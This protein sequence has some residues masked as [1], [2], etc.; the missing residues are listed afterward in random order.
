MKIRMLTVLL[1]IFCAGLCG[2]QTPAPA[3]EA[4]IKELLKLTNA[5]SLV[6]NLGPQMQGMMKTTVRQATQGKTLTPQQQKA[7]DDMQTR[8]T[9]IYTQEMSWERLE[10]MYIRIYQGSFSQSEVDGMIDFYHSPVGHSMI[11]KMPLV[12]QNMMVEI[13][14]LIVPM[15]QKIQSAAR[16]AEAANGTP[17]KSTADQAKAT[18]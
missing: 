9:A 14:K 13:Q 17:A 6:D 3:S 11:T 18:R 1:G 7:F 10:P 4:S 2:A 12:M 16:E 5:K 15:A 8:M